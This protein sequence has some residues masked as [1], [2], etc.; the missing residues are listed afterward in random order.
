MKKIF[1]LSQITLFVLA[2]I[3]LTSCEDAP[4]T[5]YVP[6]YAVESYLIVDKP[7]T[8]VVI[9]RSLAITDTFKMENSVV[10]DAVV[11]ISSPSE[12]FIL[13]YRAKPKGGGEYFNPDTTKLIQ[14]STLYTLKVTTKDGKIVTGSTTTPER[15]NWL[16]GKGPKPVYQ[17]PLDTL[18]LPSPD[19]LRFYWTPAAGVSEYLIS[20]EC[21]DTLE[22]GKYL[23]PPTNE[24]NRRMKRFFDQEDSPQ[25]L[26][27]TQ[28]GFL[29]AT[30]APFVWNAFRWYGR[31][32]LTAIAPD[33]NFVKWFKSR[34]TGNQ[35]DPN[36]GS[37]KGGVGV[38]ASA[39]I[40]TQ[41]VFVLKNQP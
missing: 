7:I 29:Q 4:P 14:P 9:S 32:Q 16:P 1:S 27:T 25:Y 15:I 34:W 21:L 22:Y 37:V 26:E 18:K 10:K 31:T 40:A 35:Y 5:G 11:E 39:S 6:E 33:Y 36:L 23:T 38:F 13:Q 17:Y 8:G 2:A 3:L 19:S 12:T 41:E 28:Y 30:Y 20:L 24:K